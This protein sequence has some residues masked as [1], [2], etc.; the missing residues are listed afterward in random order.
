[1][2]DAAEF[3]L[4]FMVEHPKHHWL[5]AGP[6]TSP[7]NNY[8][9]AEGK[10]VAV[11]MGPAMTM[12]IVREPFNNTIEAGRPLGRDPE[13]VGRL[14]AARD[15]LAPACIG[16][17]GRLLEWSEEHPE[18][19]PG[20]RHISHL[21]GL[22]PGHLFTPDATPELAAAARKSLE[23]RLAHGGG[24]T[25][26]S[27]AWPIRFWARLR[28]GDEALKNIEAPLAKS[29]LPNLFDNHPPFQIDGNFGATAAIAEMLPRSRLEE[30]D[31]LPALPRAWPDGSVK[32]LR[33]RGGFE[34]DLSWRAGRLSGVTLRST[35]GGPRTV[36]GGGNSVKLSTAAGQIYHLDG[37]LKKVG[38]DKSK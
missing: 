1:M 28:E 18:A 20:Q 29:T 14:A 37:D 24:H 13:F 23:Y 27:R 35:A 4:D 21:F 19:E 8:L 9:T 34:V 22:Y 17:D 5:V 32:G 25:G 26:W 10:K 15:R 31:L 36:R 12:R 16:R 30:V 7:E 2:K 38:W 33:A 11:D 3:Y 6:A